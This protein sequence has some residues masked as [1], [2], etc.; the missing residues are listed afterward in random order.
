M[1]PLPEEQGLVR[2]IR[3]YIFVMVACFFLQAAFLASAIRS[4][5]STE[6]WVIWGAVLAFV[7][8]AAV[9]AGVRA[10]RLS[11]RYRQ[12]KWGEE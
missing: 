2:R 7:A 11:K 12:M 10:S 6:A 3:V 9:Y 1:K 8:A 4:A 5:G